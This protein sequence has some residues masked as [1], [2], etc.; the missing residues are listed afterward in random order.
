MSANE[1]G[2]LVAVGAD[3]IG[4]GALDLAAAEAVRRETGV[5]LVHVVH[6]LVV[7]PSEPGQLEAV[8]RALT[9]VGRTVLTDAAERMRQ[10]LDGRCPVSSQLLTGRV[11]ATLA[12][13][14]SHGSLV[15]LERRDVGLVERLLTMSVSTAVAAHAHAPVLVVPHGW[16]PSADPLPVTVGV[17]HAPD[18]AGQVPVAAAYARAVGRPLVVLHAA[19]IAE[20]YQDM[21]FMDYTR[22]SWL[23]DAGEQIRTSLATSDVDPDHDLAL[24]VRWER[25]AEAL[26]EA[27]RSSSVLVLSRRAGEHGTRLGSLTRTVL[28]HAACPVLLVDRG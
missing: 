13:R 28:Q 16:T 25:P 20:P 22:R 8:D 5:E 3:G 14:G 11:A 7:V 2:V 6:S 10:R 12:D 19:W 26:V 24:E 17:D 15:V 27:S 21:V 1:Y 9:R 18:A 23:H 4:D